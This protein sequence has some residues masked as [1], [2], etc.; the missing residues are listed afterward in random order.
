MAEVKIRRY[1]E[2]D[3]EDVKE[4]FTLGMSEHIPSSCMHVLKQPLTQ[5]FLGCIF[6]ALLTSAESILLPVLAVTL[7]LAAGRQGINYMFTQYIQVSLKRDLSHIRRTYLES[8]DSCFWV[9]EFQGR[10]V[11]I[12]GCLPAENVKNVGK[13]LELKRM[14]V[15]KSH[16]GLGIAKSLCRKVAEFARECGCRGVLLYTSVVQTDAQ[17][18]YEH[19]GFQ[20]VR[21]FDAPEAVAKLTNFTLIEYWLDL[22]QQGY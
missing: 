18:L 9:A 20:K 19:M 21:E 11:G 13:F 16:R 17:K 7:I 22:K 2:D 5:M 15:R 10:V 3:D 12:V 14:S 6:L 4:I 8:P 1:H